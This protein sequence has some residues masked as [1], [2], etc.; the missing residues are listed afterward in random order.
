[1]SFHKYNIPCLMLKNMLN[2]SYSLLEEID[3]TTITNQIKKNILSLNYNFF[4]ESCLNKLMLK[5]TYL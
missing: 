3:L 2:N 5:K 1:M 4:Q